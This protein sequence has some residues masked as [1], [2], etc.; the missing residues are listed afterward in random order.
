MASGPITSWK[1]DMETSIYLYIY[2][3]IYIFIYFLYI[4][5][6]TQFHVFCPQTVYT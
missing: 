5:Q 2:I 1:I 4:F 6:K 3:F